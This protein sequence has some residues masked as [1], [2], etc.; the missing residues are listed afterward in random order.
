MRC[1]ACYVLT[2]LAYAIPAL[3]AAAAIGRLGISDRA[4]TRRPDPAWV[5]VGEPPPESW[6]ETDGDGLYPC[7]CGKVRV[8]PACEFWSREALYGEPHLF[9]YHTHGMCFVSDF[10]WELERGELDQ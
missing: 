1:R 5:V 10:P 8:T 3:L 7:P 2:F 6:V 9:R 4:I